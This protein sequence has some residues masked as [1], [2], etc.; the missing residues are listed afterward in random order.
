MQSLAEEDSL[1][2]ARCPLIDLKSKNCKF[3]CNG[4]AADKRRFA[5]SFSL[6]FICWASY[7]STNYSIEGTYCAICGRP[8][9]QVY[10]TLNQ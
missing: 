9:C 7:N 3:F 2:G 6:P 4:N 5:V 10:C 8:F 1:I